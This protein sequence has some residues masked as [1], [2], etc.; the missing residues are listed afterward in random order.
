MKIIEYFDND[1]KRYVYVCDGIK[2]S[3]LFRDIVFQEY[4]EHV[5]KVEHVNDSGK[6]STV[7]YSEK[8]VYLNY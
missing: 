5:G 6:F 7:G 2:P 1:S 8:T 3:H 4:S